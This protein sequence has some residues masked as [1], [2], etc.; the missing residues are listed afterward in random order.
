MDLTQEE[1]DRGIL[2]ITSMKLDDFYKV[3]DA[4][5]GEL[6]DKIKIYVQECIEDYSHC[7]SATPHEVATAV[8]LHKA[9]VAG[10]KSMLVDLKEIIKSNLNKD[11]MVPAMLIESFME[12]SR[13][14]TAL[15]YMKMQA[16][17]DRTQ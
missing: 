10:L 13:R 8:E 2:I 4:K 7:K 16:T 11:Y 14:T 12:V 3:I 15:K 9:Y 5:I 6:N 1:K 17:H